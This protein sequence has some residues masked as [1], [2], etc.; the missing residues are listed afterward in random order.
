MDIKELFKENM[1]VDEFSEIVGKLTQS[2]GDR[3]R[4]EYSKKLKDLESK[5]PKQMTEEEKAIQD[6]L[7][8]L[9]QKEKALALR[10]KMTE[11]GLPSELLGLIQDESHIDLLATHLNQT[12][13][14]S[15]YVP[16]NANTNLTGGVTK[17]QFKD[18]S[19]TEREKLYSTNKE[20]YMA[21][22]K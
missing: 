12:K 18:L 2:E 16:P 6:R 13:L 20:L 7:T 10:E 4:G 15:G 19:Y 8:A 9:E 11:K 14:N 17:E 5:L 1:S 3:V 22:S 21:L